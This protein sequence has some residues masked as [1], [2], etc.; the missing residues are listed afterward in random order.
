[1][2]AMIACIFE[3]VQWRSVLNGRLALGGRRRLEAL[4]DSLRRHG[5]LAVPARPGARGAA[6]GE[7]APRELV[8]RVDAKAGLGL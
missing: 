6:E 8:R 2:T 3:H 1:M 4:H 5:Q 7:R